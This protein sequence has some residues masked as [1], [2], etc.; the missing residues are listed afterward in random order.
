LVR[1]RIA[2]LLRRNV[3]LVVRLLEHQGMSGEIMAEERNLSPDLGLGTTVLTAMGATA[4]V[5]ILFLLSPWN[6]SYIANKSALGT[7]VRSPP[8]GL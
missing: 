1:L 8:F 7:H 5:A 3:S 6:V 4:L 2:P